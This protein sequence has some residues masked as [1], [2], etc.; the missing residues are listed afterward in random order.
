MFGA[1]VFIS[2]SLLMKFVNFHT[3][4]V[5]YLANP[6]S[7]HPYGQPGYLNCSRR[8]LVYNVFCSNVFFRFFTS[9]FSIPFSDDFKDILL[10]EVRENKGRVTMIRW[11]LMWIYDVI[12]HFYADIKVLRFKIIGWSVLNQTDFIGSDIYIIHM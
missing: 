9:T 1:W 4:N 11:W 2:C 5:L 8:Y 12:K 3:F 6:V 10:K 7:L